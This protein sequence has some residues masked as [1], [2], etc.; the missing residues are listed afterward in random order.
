MQLNWPY[1]GAT[2]PGAD[3]ARFS[4]PAS[5]VCLDFHGDPR[6]AR[7]VVLADGNHHMALAE[8]LAPVQPY[9]PNSI[10]IAEVHTLASSVWRP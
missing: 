4:Q 1:E 9:F 5:N 7:L 8:A 3:I 6:T 2:P 10:N